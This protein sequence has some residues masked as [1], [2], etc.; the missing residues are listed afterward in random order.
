MPARGPAGAA[1]MGAAA[2]VTSRGGRCAP[3]RRCVTPA[4]MAGVMPPP[5]LAAMLAAAERSRWPVNWQAGQANTRPGGLGTRDR[6]AGQVEEVPRSS[7]RVRLIPAASALSFRTAIRWPMLQSRVRW[8]C[9]RPASRFRT[10][11]GV[12]DGHGADLPGH[13]PGDDGF[14]RF[15]LGLPDPPP[16]PHLGQSLAAPVAPPPPRAFLSQFGGAAGHRLLAGLGIGQVHPVL[17]IVGC[18]VVACTQPT[19]HHRQTSPRHASTAPTDTPAYFQS[20]LLA[21][22]C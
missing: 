20:L 4:G 13:R 18:G 6:Q 5:S 17:A 16:V 2:R 8:L 22:V 19:S 11:R 7:T 12:A 14:G 9:R 1:V 3:A 15:V 10:P 21:V